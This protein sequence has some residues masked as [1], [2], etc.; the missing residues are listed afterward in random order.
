M[1]ERI[2]DQQWAKFFNN[3]CTEEEHRAIMEWMSTASDQE[4]ERIMEQHSELV[5]HQQ[6][7]SVDLESLDF[8]K[9]QKALHPK[10]VKSYSLKRK[11]LWKGIAAAV[12][13]ILISVYGFWQF[14]RTEVPE[15][16]AWEEVVTQSGQKKVVK[17]PDG[18]KITLNAESQLSYPNVFSDTLREV[19]LVGEAYFEVQKDTG[20]PFIVHTG[21]LDTKVLGTSF[22]VRAFP[23]D[24]EVEVALEEGKV[25][26][27]AT[28][29]VAFTPVILEPNQQ[30]IFE[31]QRHTGRV[32]GFDPLQTTGWRQNA[33]VFENAPL[34]EVL[35]ILERQYGV[36]FI[37]DVA[38]IRACQVNARFE[39]D[40]FITILQVLTTAAE[41]NYQIKGKTIQLTGKG[42]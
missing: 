29:G 26:V 27:S 33:F 7:P 42:C 9:V 38:L 34:K 14:K 23:A 30:L 32:E 31:K 24:Q 19:R 25:Q 37:V 13:V 28:T 18:T 5:M 3:N 4:V 36:S 1:E 12:T 10:S 35:K 40:S 22:N 6:V 20:K 39:E 41:L 17:L 21:D 16:V 8:S 15:P 2:S 11:P